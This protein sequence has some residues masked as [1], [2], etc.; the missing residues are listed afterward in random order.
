MSGDYITVSKAYTANASA[1]VTNLNVSVD[2]NI[3][4]SNFRLALY[5]AA[6]A[7]WN[8]VCET[9]STAIAT[10]VISIAASGSIT[11]GGTYRMAFTADGGVNVDAVSGAGNNNAT[12]DAYGAFPATLVYGAYNGDQEYLIW[13]TGGGGGSVTGRARNYYAQS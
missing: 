2:S 13:P 9:A 5:E 1:T 10:G 11:N 4:A 6:G 7:T 8:L 12:A 3:S